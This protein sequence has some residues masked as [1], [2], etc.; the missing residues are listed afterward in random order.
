MLFSAA[1]LHPCL[2]RDER[3]GLY[4]SAFNSG[5]RAAVVE[6]SAALQRDQPNV[7]FSD[8]DVDDTDYHLCATHRH[9]PARHSLEL[10]PTAHPRPG[11]FAGPIRAVG[12]DPDLPRA[13]PVVKFPT[14]PIVKFPTAGA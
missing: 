13:G 6:D 4:P 10:I 11:M 14:A 8:I 3:V 12:I 1:G 7:D 5:P 9:S 2:E